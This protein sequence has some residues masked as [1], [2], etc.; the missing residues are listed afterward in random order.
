MLFHSQITLL[1]FY[2]WIKYVLV[3]LYKMKILQSYII[4]DRDL[5]ILVFFCYFVLSKLLIKTMQVQESLYSEII[6]C[7]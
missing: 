6:D 4:M 7:K 3:N 1:I 5:Y 2:N